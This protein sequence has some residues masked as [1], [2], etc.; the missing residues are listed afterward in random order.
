MIIINKLE[1][2]H[3]NGGKNGRQYKIWWCWNQKIQILLV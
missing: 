3:K 1:S 2:I